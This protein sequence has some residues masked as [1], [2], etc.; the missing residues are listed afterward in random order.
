MTEE[1]EIA[2]REAEY[3]GKEIYVQYHDKYEIIE[4][5]EI[6]GAEVYN[7][8]YV[9]EV[10]EAYWDEDAYRVAERSMY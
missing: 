2:A 10:R 7:D 8:D 4:Y 5:L 6:D 1:L 9:D 3:A